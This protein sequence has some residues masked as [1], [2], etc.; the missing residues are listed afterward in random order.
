MLVEQRIKNKG[1]K[2]AET[3]AKKHKF[4]Q[5]QVN[6]LVLVKAENKSDA[7]SKITAKF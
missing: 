7:Y 3:H 5:Y 1:K 4:A 6:D 2:Q